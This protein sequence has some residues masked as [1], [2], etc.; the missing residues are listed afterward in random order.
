MDITAVTQLIGSIGFPIV[1]CMIMF[2]QSNEENKRHDEETKGFMEAINNNTLVITQ[3]KD[4]LEEISH[5][6]D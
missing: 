5:D 1:C 4:K 2:K 6:R 3:L